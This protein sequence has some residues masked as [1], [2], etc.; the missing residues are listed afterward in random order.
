MDEK[1]HDMLLQT[2]MGSFT[3]YD[4]EYF[5]TYD[6]AFICPTCR[7]RYCALAHVI[8]HMEFN[9]K[10]NASMQSVMVQRLKDWLDLAVPLTFEQSLKI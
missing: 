2:V 9:P 5:E 3:P 7:K 1:Y 4:S 10:C 8:A 6:G